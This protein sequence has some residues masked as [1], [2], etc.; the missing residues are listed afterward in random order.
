[1]DDLS[2]VLAKALAALFLLA[3][4]LGISY[5]Q[6]VYAWGLELKSFGW[7]IGTSLL[8]GVVVSIISALNVK[9]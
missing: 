4:A 7:F 5:L 8:S 1:M 6:M 9:K 3:C 2:T